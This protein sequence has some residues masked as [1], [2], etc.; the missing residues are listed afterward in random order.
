MATGAEWIKVKLLLL[1]VSVSQ[2]KH[3]FSKVCSAPFLL[4]AAVDGSCFPL[5]CVKRFPA[6]LNLRGAEL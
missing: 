3:N 5:L 2:P 1:L 4:R 6:Q